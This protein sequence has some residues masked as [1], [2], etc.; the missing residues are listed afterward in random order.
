ME[1]EESAVTT[2][3]L[4]FSK[5]PKLKK[6]LEL[7]ARAILE[8]DPAAVAIH[9]VKRSYPGFLAIAHYRFAHLR[10]NLKVPYCPR[11]LS[12]DAHGATGIDIHP[13]AVIGAHF[14]I[15]HGTGVVIGETI[16]IINHVKI[17][18]NVT[19]GTMSVSN[20]IA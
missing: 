20:E 14:C 7:D 11:I 9:E 19:L 3:H 5:L 1:M 8:G 12:E 4:L 17:Y 13:N 2:T 6:M 15:D 10:H 16:H 18:Y